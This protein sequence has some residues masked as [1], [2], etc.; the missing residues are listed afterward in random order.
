MGGA[1]GGTLGTFSEIHHA[2]KP[3]T[4]RDLQKNDIQFVQYGDTMVLVIPTDH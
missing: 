1:I 4:I 3:A 2:G